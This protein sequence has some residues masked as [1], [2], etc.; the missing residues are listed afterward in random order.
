MRRPG[1]T[2]VVLATLAIVPSG[3]QAR[4]PSP[5]LPADTVPSLDE[6]RRLLGPDGDRG[7]G[8]AALGAHALSLAPPRATLWI[9][10]LAAVERTDPRFAPLLLESVELADAGAGARAADHLEAAVAEAGDGDRSALLGLAAL[11]AQATDPPRASRLRER[12]LAEHPEAPE[13]PEAAYRQARW[14]LGPGGD[15]EGALAL[16]EELVVSRPGHAVAPT[17]RA[18]LLEA[19]RP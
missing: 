3:L 12:L 7:A 5:A 8:L 11:L 1:G 15:R 18:L 14:L 4:T 13:V 19:R 10:L 2:L 16:L 9:Q 17:A 6:I